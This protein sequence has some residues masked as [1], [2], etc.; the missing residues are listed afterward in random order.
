MT[1]N[2]KRRRWD[3]STFTAEIKEI[4]NALGHFPTNRELMVCGRG[5]LANQIGRRGGFIQCSKD[6]G[7][8]RLHSD[9][10]TG[11]AGEGEAMEKLAELGF[12]VSVRDG[13]KSPFDLLIS[14][15]VRV[16]V[17]SARFH[18]YGCSR[19]WFYRLGKYP[20]ADLIMLW[21]LDE[22]DFFALPWFVC[23]PSNITITPTGGKYAAFHNNVDVIH[24][25]VSWREAERRELSLSQPK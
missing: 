5:D 12:T 18:A 14:G 2:K 7:F 19:G 1:L 8:N 13:I 4:A 6:I 22:K 17:K 9:S 16:D 15:I 11:W 23:P 10:D 20:Q 25:M 24:R 3:E 21:R